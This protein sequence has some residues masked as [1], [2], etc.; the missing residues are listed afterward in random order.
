MATP[1][2]IRR[3]LGRLVA[4]ARARPELVALLALVGLGAA[5][6]FGTLGLQSFDG[7][8]TVTA[9]RVLHPSFFATMSEVARTERSP[10]LY[11]A[12]AWVWSRLFGTGEIGLRSLSALFGTLTIPF[13][14]LA[15]RE[16]ANRWAGVGAA[17]FVAVNPYLF[18]YSQEARSYA[19]VVMFVALGL[20]FFARALRD[21]RPRV[22][23]AWALVSALALTSHYFAAFVVGPEALWLLLGRPR[24]RVRLIAVMATGAAG[25]ALLPLAV[26][27]ERSGRANTFTHV[28]VLDRGATALIKFFSGEGRFRIDGLSSLSLSQI[29]AGGTSLALLALGVAYLFRQGSTT[30]RRAAKVVGLLAGLGFCVPMMLALGGVDYVDSRNLIPALVPLLVLGGIA[31]SSLRSV[32]L[33]AFGVVASGA[34]A[35]TIVAITAVNPALERN[36]W[37]RAAELVGAVHAPQVL[38]TDVP[39]AKPLEYYLGPF[40]TLT[41]SAFPDGVVTHRVDVVSEGH[42]V[43]ALGHGFRRV[44]IRRMPA[45]WQVDIFESARPREVRPSWVADRQVLDWT[46][47]AEVLD[48]QQALK[49]PSL[50]LSA[51][52]RTRQHSGPARHRDLR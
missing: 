22:L 48:P 15:A 30:E 17:F 23:V 12:L 34:A 6:R 26:H 18:W 52:A 13:A 24:T 21:P 7:G 38:V 41:P 36:D 42:P 19:L 27:Q 25:L 51:G 45:N 31:V 4:G 20:Y 35:A 39:A 16:L 47:V 49:P 43:H 46:S 29:A 50:E 5:V 40:D 9:Y 11:Y 2:S 8:E 28:P 3:A 14:Y 44:A 1:T 32:R 37:R 33:G 10:P